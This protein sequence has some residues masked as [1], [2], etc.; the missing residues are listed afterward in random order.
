M[1]L[2]FRLDVAVSEHPEELRGTMYAPCAPS[3]FLLYSWLA[4]STGDAFDV[5]MRPFETL[6]YSRIAQE[7]RDLASDYPHLAKVRLR[8]SQDDV[9]RVT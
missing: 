6:S 4:V 2:G 8:A 3:L 9:K 7:L 5:P 1:A